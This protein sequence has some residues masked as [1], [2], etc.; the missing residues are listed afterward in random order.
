MTSDKFK[1]PRLALPI[2]TSLQPPEHRRGS[3]RPL[4]PLPSILTTTAKQRPEAARSARGLSLLPPRYLLLF[5]AITPGS[6]SLM[7]VYNVSFSHPCFLP[8]LPRASSPFHA[9]SF[10]S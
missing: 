9:P 4:T 1:I 10:G 2:S 3:L 8:C 5:D 6:P 7:G